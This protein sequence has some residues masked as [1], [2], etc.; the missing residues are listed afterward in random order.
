[1]L[2]NTL[3]SYKNAQISICKHCWKNVK[4][5]NLNKEIEY[6]KENHMKIFELKNISKTLNNGFKNS[7]DM[8]KERIHKHEERPTE[9]IQSEQQSA[10]TRK[11]TSGDN[12][13][14]SNILL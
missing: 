2:E 9:M 3:N 13:K 11:R 14:R 7:K 5:E 4:I 12:N 1:M 8:T 6:I 10:K